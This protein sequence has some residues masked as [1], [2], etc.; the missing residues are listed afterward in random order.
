M[1]PSSEF[2]LQAVHLFLTYPQCP[3]HRDDLLPLLVAKVAE[4]GCEV[5]QYVVANEQH[6]NGE[7]HAHAYLGLNEKLRVRGAECFDITYNGV[8]YHGKYESARKP[9]DVIEYCKKDGQFIASLKPEK[10]T[11][12]KIFAEATEAPTAEEFMSILM[13]D[14][15]RDM[16]LGLEKVEYFCS[17]RY[18]RNV[19]PYSGRG[20]E[21]FNNVPTILTEWW[22]QNVMNPQPERPKSLI[23][24]GPTR[25]GKTE[26]A[27]A[28]GKHMYFNGMFNLDDWDDEAQYA[29]FD[30]MDWKYFI[31][32]KCWLGAQKHFTCTDKY[33][34]KQSITWGHPAIWL[35]NE[36]PL[37]VDSEGKYK[38]GLSNADADWIMKNCVIVQAIMPFWV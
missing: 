15:P 5:K 16:V 32:W 25:L 20:I 33:R 7:W 31:N 11:L 34:K 12:Q 3:V 13:R 2:R 29:I 23:L 17:K 22:Q 19:Q 35:N 38:L 14:A 6:Q 26:W 18:K 36:S 28:L 30:D 24:Y 37:A 4:Y 10:R 21:D 9:K 27:R 1:A 8:T